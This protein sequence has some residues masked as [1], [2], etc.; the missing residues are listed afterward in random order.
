MEL[1]LLKSDTAKRRFLSFQRVRAWRRSSRILLLQSLLLRGR[2]RKLDRIGR[3]D[4]VALGEFE[5]DDPDR[6]GVERILR[7]QPFI[8]NE[9]NTLAV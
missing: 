5:R 4:F 2:W 7:E 6:I 9:C 8:M 3:L 1:T